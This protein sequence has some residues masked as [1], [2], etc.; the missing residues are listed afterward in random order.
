MGDEVSRGLLVGR[1]DA[2]LE[3]SAIGGKGVC[4]EPGAAL[5]NKLN[6]TTDCSEEV[7]EVGVNIEPLLGGGSWGR[8]GK[9]AKSVD[10]FIADKRE[11]LAMT[12]PLSN[13]SFC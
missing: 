7:I 13:S 6:G 4:P 9:A 1:G 3:E 5:D 2:T 8:E 11:F 10:K 12:N